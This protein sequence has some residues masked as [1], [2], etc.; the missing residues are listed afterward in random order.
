MHPKRTYLALLMPAIVS[1][2]LFGWA[3]FGYIMPKTK[4]AVMERR[5]EMIQDLASAA[6]S[7]I[8]S[9]DAQAEAGVLT[10]TVAEARA[11]SRLRMMRYGKEGKDYFWITSLDATM[12]MHPY[13][14]DLVG[15][16][17]MDYQDPRGKRL[18]AEMVQVAKEKGAGF[19]SYMWQHYDNPDVVELKV[20]Y[21]RL[22]KPWGWIIGTGVYMADVEKEIESLTLDVVILGGIIWLVVAGLSVYITIRRISFDREQKRTQ[23]ALQDSE[24][25]LKEI[26]DFLPDATWVVDLQGRIMAWNRA[27]ED[28]TGIDARDMIGRG[29]YKHAEPFYGMR[30]PMLI[31]MVLKPD[32]M[33]ESEFDLFRVEGARLYGEISV[34]DLDGQGRYLAGTAGPLNDAQGQV[35]GAIQTIRD[36]THRKELEAKLTRLATTDSL[37]GVNNRHHFLQLAREELLRA[38]R[39]NRSLAMLM[40][41]LDRFKNVN[42]T[43]GHHVGDRVLIEFSQACQDVIRGS[44]CFGRLGGEEFAVLLVET[45]QADAHQVAE[46]IRTKVEEMT[47]LAEGHRIKFTVSVGLTTLQKADA[48][49][50]QMMQRADTALYAAKDAGR[51]QVAER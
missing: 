25:R 34:Q 40:L 19:V 10:R 43:Y 48:Y 41:D 30:K 44:D 49:F 36:I 32:P 21:V 29:N 28:L 33:L 9:Y 45:G 47:V 15:Q 11:L 1:G 6:Y 27:M 38:K 17:L 22:Y 2:V 3:L 39:Y 13:R 7:V 26:I 14:T 24:R 46:R 31:D 42:D 5:R 18:F 23:S 37:T 35:V 20:S 50:K 12:I 51:N 4:D 8:A 16:D